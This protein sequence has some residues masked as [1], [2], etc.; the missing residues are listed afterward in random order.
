[1]KTRKL[2]TRIE[3]LE[4]ILTRFATDVSMAIRELCRELDEH[5]TGK[6]TVRGNDSVKLGEVS[7]RKYR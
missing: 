6:R 5:R 7:V 4:R 3:E 2:P 1:M